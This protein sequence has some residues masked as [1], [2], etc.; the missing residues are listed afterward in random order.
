M[1]NVAELVVAYYACFR[2]GAIAAPLNTKLKLAELRPLLERLQ[3][4]LYIG[5]AELY[6]R[7]AAID[8]SIIPSNARYIIG[9]TVDDPWAQP[10]TRLLEDSNAEPVGAEPNTDAPAVLLATSGTTGRPKFAIHTQATLSAVVAAASHLELDGD[11]IAIIPLPLAHGFGL[12]TFPAS[13]RFGAPV[14][15]L[16]RL[17]PMPYSMQSSVI[18][19]LGSLRC[20]RCMARCWNANGHAGGMST[21]CGC[22]CHQVTSVHPGCRS[23]FSPYLGP[24]C[25]IFGARRRR[26]ALS[27]T[28]W[29]RDR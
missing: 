15:L 9:D 4:A 7:I 27:P 1:T 6:R 17:I 8:T 13:I 29:S 12:F 19:A 3:P 26:L 14:V 20:P 22:A 2:I 24:D 23:S 28:D 18:G 21:L 5:Q 10:W 11:Q 16:E 25:A